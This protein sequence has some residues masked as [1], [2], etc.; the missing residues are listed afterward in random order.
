[1]IQYVCTGNC[2]NCFYFLNQSKRLTVE[3]LMIRNGGSPMSF[4]MGSS[5]LFA[6]LPTPH[7]LITIKV[8]IIIPLD[9]ILCS[10]LAIK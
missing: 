7:L 5:Q 1:M 9:K 4:K 6:Q 10:N 2:K 8:F 3:A